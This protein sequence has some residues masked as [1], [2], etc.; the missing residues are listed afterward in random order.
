MLSNSIEPEVEI[1]RHH[2]RAPWSYAALDLRQRDILAR[3]QA[4]G[5]GALLLSEVAPVITI[6][7]RTNPGDILLSPEILKRQGVELHTT[8]RGGLATYHGP[9][10]WVLFAVDSLARLTGDSRGVRLAVNGLLE[11][12]LEVGRQFEP[13]AEIRSGAETGVWGPHGKFAAVGIHIAQGVVLHGLCVNGFRTSTSFVGLRP[14]GLDLPVGFLLSQVQPDGQP[15]GQEEA[16]VSL[17]ESL[18]S[19]ALKKFWNRESGV[20]GVTSSG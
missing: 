13:K 18:R 14:C 10:Q 20:D 15:E 12:A 5:A 2:S 11:I 3:V 9:G 19:A 1:K 4:G 6:G 17:G 16:F 8:D 7:R